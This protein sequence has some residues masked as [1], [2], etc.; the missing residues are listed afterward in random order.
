MFP[1]TLPSA[2]T[3]AAREG[4]ILCAVQDGEV[5][6]N[7]KRQHH[8]AHEG[9]TAERGV[10]DS[11]PSVVQD[12]PSKEDGVEADDYDATIQSPASTLADTLSLL[13][14]A[15]PAAVDS[16]SSRLGQ[17][18]QQ[19]VD[20]GHHASSQTA[21]SQTKETSDNNDASRIAVRKPAKAQEGDVAV[22]LVYDA[23]M[24]EHRG[25]PGDTSQSSLALYDLQ[26]SSVAVCLKG[27]ALKDQH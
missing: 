24:E 6:T 15:T 13:S 27:V 17:N 8:S 20:D 5:L 11:T 9:Q 25:P 22:G 4:G 16:K 3:A 10:S 21:D 7:D 14:L 1:D 23:I 19:K 12:T 26:M 2:N 18:G